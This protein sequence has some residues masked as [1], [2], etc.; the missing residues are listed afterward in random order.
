MPAKQFIHFHSELFQD[1]QSV[2][3]VLTV[4]N[5]RRNR[6][7]KEYVVF[8]TNKEQEQPYVNEHE[9]LVF[10]DLLCYSHY[11]LG[12]FQLSLED[13]KYRICVGRNVRPSTE[14]LHSQVSRWM[15][16]SSSRK[17]DLL[18]HYDAI[19][20]C[21]ARY[22]GNEISCTQTFNRHRLKPPQHQSKGLSNSFHSPTYQEALY[23][24]GSILTRL[25]HPFASDRP[26]V[27]RTLV[28]RICPSS[29][30]WKWD[31]PLMKGQLE[32]EV[33]NLSVDNESVSIVLSWDDV[34]RCT[35]IDLRARSDE[36]VQSWIAQTSKLYSCLRSRGYGDDLG[37]YIIEGVAFTITISP[38]D[39]DRD[40]PCHVCNAKDRYHQALS[41]SITA[42]VIDYQTNTIVSLPVVSC[43]RVCGMDSLEEEDVFT[44]KVSGRESHAQWGWILRHMV[45]MS[46][47]ELNAEHGFDPA[48]EG[49]DV[50]NHFGWPL[51]ELFD[52]STGGG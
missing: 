13:G 22:V 34:Y 7:R 24:P 14:P 12:P 15:S 4:A 36:I 46:I 45:N 26:R 35:T 50:C 33:V 19:I 2:S 5:D 31:A 30:E 18:N 17:N 32:E 48:R 29:H 38:K 3:E 39:G 16:S 21:H 28:G 40:G 20:F 25:Q 49:A 42:P 41:L 10:G 11:I 51:L 37:A 44:V 27:P 1:L 23:A 9:K 43:S 6:S 8:S 47:P 52:S